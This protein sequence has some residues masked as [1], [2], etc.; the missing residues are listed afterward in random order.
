MSI[1]AGELRHRVTF[2]TNTPTA[3][4]IGE[5]VDTYSDYITVWGADRPLSGVKL[6]QS[7]QANSNVTGEVEIRYYAGIEPDMRMVIGS[8]T[9]EIVSI[10]NPGSRNEKLLILYK[11]KLD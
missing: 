6:F 7:Q 9:L 3:N 2:Q 4:S 10:I 8:R 11:E 5:F 1:R